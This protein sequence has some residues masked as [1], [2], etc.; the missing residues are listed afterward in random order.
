[1][2]KDSMILKGWEWYCR[3]EY[4]AEG[5]DLIITTSPGTDFWQRTHYGFRNDNGHC[6]LRPAEGDFSLSVKTSYRA[7]AQYD[8]CG[9]ILRVDEDNWIK[10][11]TEYE[12]GTHSR[13]G[14]VV[15]NRG[16]SDWATIDLEEEVHEMWYRIRSK[17]GLSDFLIEYSREGQKWKQLR[18]CHLQESGSP[19]KIGV[20][21]C[22]PSESSFDVRFSRFSLE[23]TD[24]E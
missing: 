3:P 22:S 24:W 7:K 16:Y 10:T 21:A 15:T 19:L 4:R 13:L 8:Q 2:I 14:S 18:I 11:S 20:Y 1:M 9:L 12:S 5:E 17:N 23:I 6:L